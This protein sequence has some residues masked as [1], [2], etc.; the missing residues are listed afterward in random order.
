MYKQITRKMALITSRTSRSNARN[1]LTQVAVGRVE[2]H[3]IVPAVTQEQCMTEMSTCL[4]NMGAMLGSLYNRF[5]QFID[6]Q[7]RN[8]ETV[9]AIAM[10]LASTSRQVLSAV[11]PSAA[12]SFDQMSEEETKVAVLVNMLNLME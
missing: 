7:R 1:S 10:S 3:L 6:I 5:S 11:T 2:Q 12:P 4:D 8:T 9:G